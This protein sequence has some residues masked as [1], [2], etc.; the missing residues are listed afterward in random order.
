[1]KTIIVLCMIV[2]AA[3]VSEAQWVQT[4]GPYSGNVTCF[5]VNGTN[6]FA[7]TYGSGVFLSTNNGTSWVSVSTG[8][9]NTNVEALAVS[10]TDLFAGTSRSLSE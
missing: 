9:T 3:S 6:L 10:G 4:N 2:L 1:M 8:L 5:A 7:G